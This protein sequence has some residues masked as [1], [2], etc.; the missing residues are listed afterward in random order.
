ML[1]Q[2]QF[3]IIIGLAYLNLMNL[4]I[5]GAGGHGKV[6]ADLSRLLNLYKK[7]CFLDDNKNIGSYV[8]DFKIENKVDYDYIKKI[9]SKE[10]IF[11]VAIGDCK[12]RKEI[13][14]NLLK[15][16]TNIATLI[17]PL[18][19]ISSYAKIGFGTVICAGAV[20]GADSNVGVG[21]ILNH[22]STVDHDCVVGNYTHISPHSSL[23]GNVDFGELSFLGT[24]AR[25]IGGKKVGKNCKIGAGAVVV[26]DIPDNKI[27]K[28]IPAKF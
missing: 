11:F 18:S 25:I 16:N 15:L 19:S 14:N 22:S 6:V 17:H 21:S 24:G 9:N 20:L 23:S 8:L 27:A 28:G 2:K 26:S 10:N 5:V 12:V 13:L 7:I 1:K 4:Y 3:F